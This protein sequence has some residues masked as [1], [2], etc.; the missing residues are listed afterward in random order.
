VGKVRITAMLDLARD[1]FNHVPAADR[2]YSTLTMFISRQ[3]YQA[4]QDRLKAFRQEV[5]SI[6]EQDAAE[7]RIYTLNFQL[8]PNN[9]LPEWG[10]RPGGRA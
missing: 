8:F 2:E 10:P 9:H 5:K 7:D 3:G 1:V 4:V 6:V